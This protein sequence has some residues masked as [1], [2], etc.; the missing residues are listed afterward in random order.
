MRIDSQAIRQKEMEDDRAKAGTENE[1]LNFLGKSRGEKLTAILIIGHYYSLGL[2]SKIKRCSV[3]SVSLF[4]SA[5]VAP[6][7]RWETGNIRNTKKERNSEKVG[8]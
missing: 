4:K 8:R 7:L 6:R 1:A 2:S 5:T 3:F